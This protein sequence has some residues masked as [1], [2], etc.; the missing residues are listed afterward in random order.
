MRYI[1]FV[2]VFHMQASTLDQVSSLLRGVA[3]WCSQVIARGPVLA[4]VCV[5]LGEEIVS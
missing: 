4:G 3:W 1:R 2:A 5:A